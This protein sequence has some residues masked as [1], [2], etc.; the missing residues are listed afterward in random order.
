MKRLFLLSSALILAAPAYAA[1][2][3]GG[4][5]GW[6]MDPVTNTAFLALVVFLFIV[7]RMGGF[8]TVTKALDSRAEGIEKELNEARDLREKASK[9]LAEAERRQRDADEEAKAIVAQAKK[10]AKAMMEQARADLDAR[11]KRREAQAEGRIARA[12]ADAAAEVRRAAA[13]AATQA[14]RSILTGEA[15]DKQFDRAIADIEKALS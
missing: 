10:D 1:S 12:E 2:D 15:G 5:F 4:P 11:L 3:K 8:S 7:W 13:D 9:A 6:L 14:A